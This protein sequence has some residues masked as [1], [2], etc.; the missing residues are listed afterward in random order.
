MPLALKAIKI[1]GIRI[2][3]RIDEREKIARE[4]EPIR[5]NN[6]RE[7]MRLRER[8]SSENSNKG[9]IDI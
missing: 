2:V 8:R 4:N 3:V 5:E 9:K 6:H 7:R 1:V